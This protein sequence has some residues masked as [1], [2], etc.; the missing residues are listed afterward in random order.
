[1]LDPFT[2]FLPPILTE[3]SEVLIVSVFVPSVLILVATTVPI[4]ELLK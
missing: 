1:M 4:G 2:T 3:F